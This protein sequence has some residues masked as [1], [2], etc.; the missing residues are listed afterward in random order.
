MK[1]EAERLITLYESDMLRAFCYALERIEGRHKVPTAIQIGDVMYH[2]Q[3]TVGVEGDRVAVEIE[4]DSEESCEACDALLTDA[5]ADDDDADVSEVQ[6][7][8]AHDSVAPGEA[9]QAP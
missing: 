6:K 1:E 8:E 9:P 3:C 7:A 2:G 4:E 5:P